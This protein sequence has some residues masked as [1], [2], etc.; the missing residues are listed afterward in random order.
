[1]ET[2][3]GKIPLGKSSGIWDDTIGEAWCKDVGWIQL[4]EDLVNKLLNLPIP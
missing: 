1:M 3:A 4:V 2:P